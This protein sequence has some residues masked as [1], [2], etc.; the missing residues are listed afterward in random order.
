V[1]KEKEPKRK[2]FYPPDGPLEGMLA[3]NG[4]ARLRDANDK[5]EESAGGIG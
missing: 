4:G 1:N 5:N 2:T 3:S